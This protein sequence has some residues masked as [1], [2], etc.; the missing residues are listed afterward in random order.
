M[1]LNSSA[2]K[3]LPSRFHDSFPGAKADHSEVLNGSA[4]NLVW[5]ETG[6][7]T[8]QRYI[9]KS[10]ETACPMDSLAG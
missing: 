5:D 7:F 3:K 2:E 9:D 10:W 4:A 1:R 8:S 6:S